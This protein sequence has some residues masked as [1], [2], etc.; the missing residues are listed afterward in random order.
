MHCRG[1][2]Q[3]RGPRPDCALNP[4][5]VEQVGAPAVVL[6]GDDEAAASGGAEML[7]GRALLRLELAQRHRGELIVE[8]GQKS[9]ER[10]PLFVEE[11]GC[12]VGWRV[13]DGSAS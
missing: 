5:R 4:D 7:D 6:G 3:R 13:H 10:G 8:T 2:R 11:G 9:L 1:D 12:R